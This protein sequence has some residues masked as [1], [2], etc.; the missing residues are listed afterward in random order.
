MVIK[1]QF[2]QKN[3]WGMLVVGLTCAGENYPDV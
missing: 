1:V 2:D 3:K